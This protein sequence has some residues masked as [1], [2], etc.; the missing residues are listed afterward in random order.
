VSDAWQDAQLASRTTAPHSAQNRPAA[1]APQLGQGTDAEEACPVVVG[2]SD[3]E[4]RGN[5]GLHEGR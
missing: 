5:V 3:M 1:G 2:D 4:R